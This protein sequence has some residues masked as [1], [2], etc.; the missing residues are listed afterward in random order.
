MRGDGNHAPKSST[1]TITKDGDLVDKAVFSGHCKHTLGGIFMPFNTNQ[2]GMN[3]RK[4]I[5][6]FSYKDIPANE[7]P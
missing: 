6:E 2:S 7:M 3:S 5:F 4:G 1:M